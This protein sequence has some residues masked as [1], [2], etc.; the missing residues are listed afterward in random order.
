VPMHTTS[1]NENSSLLKTRPV[2]APPG[3]SCTYSE[4]LPLWEN[5]SC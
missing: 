1:K 3:D 5:N 2:I 4:D